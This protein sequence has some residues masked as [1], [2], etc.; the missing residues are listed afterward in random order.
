MG[1]AIPRKIHDADGNLLGQWVDTLGHDSLYDYDP[2]WRKCEELGVV[3]TFHAGGQGWGSRMS[4][5]NN[6]YNQVGNFAA[7]DEATCRSLVF[8]GVP[9]RFPNL[10]FAFQEGGVAWVSSLL[11]GILTHWDKR[12]IDRIQH[13]N[14]AH[15]DQEQLATLFKTYARGPVADRIDQLGDGLSGL[16]DPEEDLSHIDM[17][18]ESLIGSD[19]DII[20]IF[21]KRF[22]YGCEA[23]DPLNSLAF[24]TSISPAGARF[25]AVFASDIGH[26]DV[27]DMRE[28]LP[29]AYEL[30]EHGHVNDEE[31]RDFVFGNPVKLWATMNPDF[32]AGT[33]VEGAVARELAG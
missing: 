33:A 2:V 6:S 17:F 27:R 15:L 21:S 30:I 9:M 1:G 24:N 16:S 19:E 11:A 4:T 3:P 5:T 14:P 29:E 23:D 31:F 20:D 18:A 32:F 13:Y 25:P 22:F 10:V 28:V 8:G 7:A 12:R 26:W